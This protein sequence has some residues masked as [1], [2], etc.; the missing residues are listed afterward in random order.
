MSL[1]FIMLGMIGIRRYLHRYFI[2]LGEGNE[3]SELNFIL[4][5]I[6]VLLIVVAGSIINDY[7]DVRSDR[8]NRPLRVVVDKKLKKRWA[9]IFHWTFSCLALL[10]A[11]YLSW[12]YSTFVFVIVH[13]LS[14]LLLWLF[15][16]SWK[17]KSFIGTITIAFLIV[18][19]AFIT[20]EWTKLDTSISSSIFRKIPDQT[21]GIP[22]VFVIIAYIM[23]IFLQIIAREL[24]KNIENVRGDIASNNKTLIVILGIPNSKR[25]I[26]FIIILFPIFYISFLIISFYLSLS[27]HWSYTWAIFLIALINLGI[28]FSLHQEKYI[29]SIGNLKL[30]TE[31]TVLL[32]IIHFFVL[33]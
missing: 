6:S 7:F 16:V 9:I 17:K 12:Y 5:V 13:A 25:I 21:F 31:M 33:G 18:L 19:V 24:F 29:I 32:M 2:S 30:F 20:I 4:L 3:H 26:K 14:I 23:I 15:C 10:I 28:F 22:M 27:I 1:I 8:V 11:I